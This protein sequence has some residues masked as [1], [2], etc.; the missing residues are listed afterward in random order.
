[1]SGKLPSDIPLSLCRKEALMIVRRT[2][3]ARIED[4]VAISRVCVASVATLATL[5]RQAERLM[6]GDL[7]EYSLDFS[8]SG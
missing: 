5:R 3:M 4:A 1:M 2:A 7:D 8:P 6:F